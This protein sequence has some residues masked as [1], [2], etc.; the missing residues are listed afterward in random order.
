MSLFSRVAN[1]FRLNRLDREIDEEFASHLAEA[2]DRGRDPGEAA[3]AF[4][5]PLRLREESRDARVFAWLGSLRAD[6]VFGWRQLVKHKITSA[7]AILSLGLAIGACTGA[8]R[9]IEALL[10]RPLPVA[11]PEDLYSVA[12]QGFDETGSRPITINNWA[13]PDFALM[14]DAVRGRASLIAISFTERDDVSYGSDSAIEKANVEYVSGSM[15]EL[16][17]LR[18]ALGRLLTAN[19]DRKPGAHPYAVLSYDYWSS[20]FGRDPG[21]VGR[22]FRFGERVFEIVGVG[23]E[24][25][26]GTDTGTLVDVFLP[27]MMHPGV[28]RDDWTW[29]RIFATIPPGTALEPIRSELDSTSL[30]FERERASHFTNFPAGAL[31][32]FLA[33]TV[34]LE[35]A[36]AGVSDMQSNYRTA[37]WTM[38]VLVG[39]VLLIACANVA[40]LLTAQAAGRARE[41][42]MRVSIGAGRWRLVQ[43][44]LVESAW[45]AAF[46]AALGG[47]F[48]WWA[49]PFV[50]S[51]IS[52][53][54]NPVH[55]LLPA[56]WRVIAFGIA[57]TVAVMLLFGLAPAVRASGVQPASALKGGT[58]PHARR[59]LMQVLI[60]VQVTF[61]FVVLFAANLFASTFEHL[62]N[63]PVGFAADRLL[64]VYA[65]TERPVAPVF[66]EQVAGDLR[67]LPE[68]ESVGISRFPLLGGDAWNGFISVNG[69][70]ANG[71]LAYFDAISPGWLDTM[72]IRLVAG[73]DFRAS[74]A[75]PGA[76]IVNET[77]VKQFLAGMNPLEQSIAKGPAAYR[78]VGVVQDTPYRSIH[79]PTLPVVFVPFLTMDSKGL[80]A[81]WRAATFLVRTR[82]AEPMSMASVLRR[83]V[84]RARSEFRV[85]NV[86]AQSELVRAQTIRERL[87]A[88]LALFF[89]GVAL[90]LGSIGLYGVLDY[91]VLQRRRE[92]GI[93][94]AIGAP[95]ASIVRGVTSGALVTVA[96]GVVAGIG[97]GMALVQYV[98]SL[99]YEVRSN[100]PALLVLPLV[101]VFTAAMVAAAPAAVRAVRIDPA[102]TLRTE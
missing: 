71:I 48:A 23:P 63:R 56:D 12:R 78:I 89:A 11:H 13:Y 83:E 91:S 10:L 14:R 58:D 46:S 98:A 79:E 49:A 38:A 24:R 36:A 26:T 90:L 31:K 40:N 47:W 54:D 61:C 68:V 67:S 30:T 34:V 16:F 96:V 69:G 43:L 75:S 95:A 80:P 52:A 18:P 7:A 81:P 5:S 45:L 84:P 33:Q 72:K 76:A 35:P 93:R 66:W 82:T 100:D 92:I 19:D 57:L 4:G 55:L 101:V 28:V 59:R 39:L 8:F 17:G 74:D 65:V 64:A 94:M 29:M 51:R 32:K 85:S 25:F 1:V 37:L 3:R 88:T 87:L 77:F 102:R 9:L 53:R 50:V 2:E 15:F 97:A 73:R 99:L 62:S 20:R 70:P 44:V 6:A 60:A 42:A 41:M 27:T 22:T 21:V 86:V